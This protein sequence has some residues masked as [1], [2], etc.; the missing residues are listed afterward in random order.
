[1]I[2]AFLILLL[3]F[4]QSTVNGPAKISG[5]AT[6]PAPST[7]SA[8]VFKRSASFDSGTVASVSALDLGAPVSAAGDL[9]VLNF[10]EASAASPTIGTPTAVCD[11]TTSGTCT[12]SAST[13]TFGATTCQPP[14]SGYSC[15]TIAWTCNAAANVRYFS[16][17]LNSSATAV[18]E[19]VT[20]MDVKHNVTSGCADAQ[21]TGTISSSM[22]STLTSNS[23]S[24]SV[25]NEIA[26]AVYGDD[27]NCGPSWTGSFG[28]G[29]TLTAIASACSSM[30]GASEY[31]IYTSTQ[32]G[33]TASFTAGNS[34][35]NP[36]SMRV[37]TFE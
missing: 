20:I 14:G 7:G 28:S 16:A 27:N 5:P 30:L 18:D 12:S 17:T 11:S 25:A 31:Q 33:V 13:Y 22:P 24:T 2:R 26:I 35:G 15:T 29:F 37:T 3:I 32:S 1:M 8:L 36:V 6:L 21:P 9:V 4:G 10:T 34:A 23:Y 19:T